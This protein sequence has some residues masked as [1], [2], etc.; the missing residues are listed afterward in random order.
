[1]YTLRETEVLNAV[2][3]LEKIA[4]LLS[5]APPPEIGQLQETIRQEFGVELEQRQLDYLLSRDGRQTVFPVAEQTL[6]E[7]LQKGV[8][9]GDPRLGRDNQ[10]ELWRWENGQKLTLTLDREEMLTLS[11]AAQEARRNIGELDLPPI[12]E[13]AADQLAE[14]LVR[15]TAY[16]N[17]SITEAKRQE[18]R[19]SVRPVTGRIF[20]G[21]PVIE[22]GE[23]INA[24]DMQKIRI[25]RSNTPRLEAGEVVAALLFLL[26]VFFLG[27]VLC[28]PLLQR[29]YR[30][31][32]HS[33]LLLAVSAVFSLN[34]LVAVIFSLIPANLP[35]A[36]G[37]LTVYDVMLVS[38]LVKRRLGV[39]MSLLLSL[40]FMLLPGVGMY[41]FLFSFFSGIFTAYLI[42]NAEKRIDLVTGTVKIA[43]VITALL[44]VIGLMQEETAAWFATAA[45]VGIIN[46]GISGGLLLATLPIFEHLLNAPTVF[47]LREL[48]DTSTPIFKRMIT[49]APGTYSHSVGVAHLA[50]SACREIGANEL[51]ARVGA[52]YHD[53]GKLDQPEYFIENQTDYNRHDDI[54]P[55]LSVAVIKSHVKLGKEKA[56][57]LKLP[58]EIVEIVA[59]HHGSDVINYF[60][61]QAKEQAK[62]PVGPEQYSYN[63]VPPRSKEAAVVMLADTIEAQSRTV[64]KP[65]MQ[66]F[67]KMVWDA[68]MYKFNKKQLSN[69]D[70]SMKELE[71]IKRSFVQ[72]LAGQFHSRIEYPNNRELG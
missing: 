43:A 46:I 10:A 67:E 8:L 56:K 55:N 19:E 42:Q 11:T 32:Q 60:Y 9:P 12:A 51:I 5:S 61:H 41:S 62:G 29:T 25:I 48:S 23:V 59:D 24:A 52:Y 30:G 22:K 65:T 37:V 26:G 34:I 38:I 45:G 4:S 15:Q 3:D 57:E 66:R 64:K 1:V 69:C 39:I 2:R 58:P 63:G 21:D 17:T 28:A 7:L 13:R 50:E 47:R 68:I 40:L 33:I 71:L 14:A 72:I 36:L 20:E 53:I 16:Y 44:V 18:A 70:L 6:Q 54:S 31:L 27:Y 49:I 35:F